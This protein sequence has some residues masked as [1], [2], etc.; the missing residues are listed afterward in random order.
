MRGRGRCDALPD[1]GSNQLGFPHFTRSDRQSLRMVLPVRQGLCR[2]RS[3]AGT[4]EN[5]PLSVRGLAARDNGGAMIVGHVDA[6]APADRCWRKLVTHAALTVRCAIARSSS[7]R[8]CGGPLRAAEAMCLA[9][10]GDGTR[11]PRLSAVLR[12]FSA[13]KYGGVPGSPCHRD[14]LYLPALSLILGDVPRALM[15]WPAEAGHPRL[16]R[17]QQKESRGWPASA[18]HDTDGACHVVRTRQY[19][20]GPWY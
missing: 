18:G 12:I 11:P 20:R 19:F 6:R 17:V 8:R 5:L 14:D 3:A 9:G 15:S 4:S 16:C 10:C 1:R 13:M 2:R 7:R